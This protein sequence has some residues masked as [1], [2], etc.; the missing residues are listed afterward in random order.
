MNPLGLAI[1]PGAVI[2][3]AFVAARRMKT[4]DGFTLLLEDG[5]RLLKE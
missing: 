4:E 5:G 2:V 1:V 3:A